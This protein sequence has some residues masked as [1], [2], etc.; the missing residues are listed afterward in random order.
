MRVLLHLRAQRHP[1]ANPMV[2]FAIGNFMFF[3]GIEFETLG[4]YRLLNA[5]IRIV[6]EDLNP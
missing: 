5:V 4:K 6:K 3:S 2:R 1:T